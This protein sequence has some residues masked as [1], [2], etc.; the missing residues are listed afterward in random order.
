MNSVRACR[1]RLGKTAAIFNF[2]S[3]WRLTATY[4]SMADLLCCAHHASTAGYIITHVTAFSQHFSR[5]T[6]IWSSNRFLLWKAKAGEKTFHD[7]WVCWEIFSLAKITQN[8]QWMKPEIHI[9]TRNTVLYVDRLCDLVVRVSGYKGPGFDSRPYQ[10]S[11]EVGI[12]N[13]VHSAS[14]GQLRSY[15]KGKVAAPV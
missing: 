14:W 5:L 6:H 11:W 13:R 1:P 8:F 7:S 2:V 10:I 3:L 9:N 4:I 15:F 12:W